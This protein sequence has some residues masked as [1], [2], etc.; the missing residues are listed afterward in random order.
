MVD[1]ETLTLA[2]ANPHE[3]LGNHKKIN[4]F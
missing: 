3:N 1:R 2:K 4:K